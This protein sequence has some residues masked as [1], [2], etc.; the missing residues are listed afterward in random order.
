MHL[1]T[2]PPGLD[3][4]SCPTS[5]DCENNAVD[6]YWKRASM[7]VILGRASEGGACVDS[8]NWIPGCYLVSARLPFHCHDFSDSFS[9]PYKDVRV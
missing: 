3:Y 7:Q 9:L 6:S 2:F 1:C 4:Q 8:M 5:E